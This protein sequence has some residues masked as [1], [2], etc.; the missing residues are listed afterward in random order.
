MAN[1]HASTACTFARF[2]TT[3]IDTCVVLLG[4]TSIPIFSPHLA[5]RAPLPIHAHYAHTHACIV[6]FIKAIPIEKQELRGLYSC[7][8]FKTK[9]RGRANEQVAVG[10]CPGF[11]WSLNLKTKANPN[12]WVLAGVAMLLSH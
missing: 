5:T 4:A 10:V 6:L 9:E 1:T 3:Y 8:T 11:V 7:P 12:K 2:I